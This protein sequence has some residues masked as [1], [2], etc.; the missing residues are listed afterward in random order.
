[1]K[2]VIIGVIAVVAIGGALQLGLYY[3]DKRAQTAAQV[4]AK[5]K[6]D[7]ATK[8]AQCFVDAIKLPAAQQTLSVFVD[9]HL[10]NL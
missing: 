10:N 4:A 8:F 1:M 7:K 9:C 5:A 2:K 3:G 6:Q